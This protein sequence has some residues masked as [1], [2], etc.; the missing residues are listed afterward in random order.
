MQQQAAPIKSVTERFKN[1]RDN[2]ESMKLIPPTKIAPI[3]I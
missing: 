3:N 2:D 1:V